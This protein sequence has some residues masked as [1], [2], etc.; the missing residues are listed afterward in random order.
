MVFWHTASNAYIPPYQTADVATE[1]REQG[2]PSRRAFT[3]MMVGG[4]GVT[5]ASSIK[6]FV[7]DA[8]S[9]MLPAAD[10]LA[11]ASIEV[12]LSGVAPGQTITVSW[13]GACVAGWPFCGG[14]AERSV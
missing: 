14:S 8:V 5:A 7:V 12:D 13:R 3:Y 9:T 1:K 6:S 11:L 4:L 2:D 10:V